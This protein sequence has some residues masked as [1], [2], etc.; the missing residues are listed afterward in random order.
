MW[1]RHQPQSS[2]ES[3]S[4]DPPVAGEHK[5]SAWQRPV[6]ALLGPAEAALETTQ[7]TVQAVASLWP[8][9]NGGQQRIVAAFLCQRSLS[10]VAAAA[11]VESQRESLRAG[12]LRRSEDL[13]DVADAETGM[14]V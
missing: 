6:Q 7:E 8:D 11:L 1:P 5:D 10:T 14:G 12:A 13:A 9:L 4:F 3:D 2:A